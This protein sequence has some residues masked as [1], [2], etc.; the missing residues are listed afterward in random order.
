[1]QRGFDDAKA[2]G[3]DP[4]LGTA[5]TP[6]AKE[7]RDGH[8]QARRDAFDGIELE[9]ERAPLWPVVPAPDVAPSKPIPEGVL[10]QHSHKIHD[11]DLVARVVG[12]VEGFVA[13]DNIREGQVVVIDDAHVPSLPAATPAPAKKRKPKP[14]DADQLSLL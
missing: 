5:D 9:G 12:T 3:I 8:R 13:L 14:V 4:I 10:I 1:M 7:Y 2:G 6:E 11:F